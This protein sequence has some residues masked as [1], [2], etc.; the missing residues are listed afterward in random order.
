MTV[1]NVLVQDLRTCKLLL[2]PVVYP[3]AMLAGGSEN[4][5]L[6]VGVNW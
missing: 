4:R 1:G 5:G 2:E 6:K 3:A